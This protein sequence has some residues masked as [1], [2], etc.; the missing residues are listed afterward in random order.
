MSSG[1]DLFVRLLYGARISLFVGVVTT[2]IGTVLGVS[3]GLVAGYFGGRHGKSTNMQNDSWATRTRTCTAAGISGHLLV[4]PPPARRARRAGL[5]GQADRGRR[6][7]A[8]FVVGQILLIGVFL[9]LNK[10]QDRARQRAARTPRHSPPC[11]AIWAHASGVPGDR[12]GQPSSHHP[13]RAHRRRVR[14]GRQHRRRLLLRI[15]RH[16]G[17]S[18]SVIV[19]VP[20]EPR[21]V[22]C[23]RLWPGLCA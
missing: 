8:M 2:A 14:R 10:H 7:G 15:A 3:A 9:Q 12:P 1:R 13:I 5:P 16:G 21:T 23:W 6:G 11:A 17:G 19:R 20:G 4:R 22:M 18:R